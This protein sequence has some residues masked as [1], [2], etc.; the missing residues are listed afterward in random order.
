MTEAWEMVAAIGEALERVP[1]RYRI[2][3]VREDAPPTIEVF[4]WIVVSDKR[5]SIT[6]TWAMSTMGSMPT[7]T[8]RNFVWMDI[9]AAYQKLTSGLAT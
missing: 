6:H 4:M 5:L 2:T 3:V 8:V 1:V 7:Q 9:S